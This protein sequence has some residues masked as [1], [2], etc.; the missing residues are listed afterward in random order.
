MGAFSILSRRP[1]LFA[2]AVGVGLALAGTPAWALIDVWGWVD[3]YGT[4]HFAPEQRDARY[5]L[6]FR[7]PDPF[8]PDESPAAGADPADPPSAASQRLHRLL[9]I[10][11]GAKAVARP[12]RVAAEATGLDFELLQALIATESGFDPGAVSPRGAVGLM[13]LLPTTAQQYGVTDSEPHLVVRKLTDPVT[14]IRAGT[15]HLRYL[16]NLFPGQLELALAAYN[17][18]EGAVQ[19]AGNRI[20]NYPETQNYV[21]TVMQLYRALKPGGNP[22]AAPVRVRVE[23]PAMVERTPPGLPPA[24][25][26]TAPPES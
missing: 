18:G 17:A 8:D 14:N 12:L 19:R 25:P 4:A 1:R 21:K 20:P 5:R 15:R 11:P 7:A 22:H 9:A 24:K 2:A 23:I 26:F 10:S 13:Q 6:L 16:V 3:D